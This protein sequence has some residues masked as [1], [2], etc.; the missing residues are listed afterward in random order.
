MRPSHSQLF[1]EVTRTWGEQVSPHII[2]SFSLLIVVF[3]NFVLIPHTLVGLIEEV[4]YTIVKSGNSV[5][6]PFPLPPATT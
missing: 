2:F 6:F 3:S 1:M 4:I 5:R